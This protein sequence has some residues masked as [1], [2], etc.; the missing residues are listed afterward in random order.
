[1]QFLLSKRDNLFLVL[2]LIFLS[3]IVYSKFA[4]SL[5]MILLV[6]LSLLPDGK[7][8]IRED[9]NLLFSNK[10]LLSITLFFFI[11]FISGVNSEN[12]GEWLHQI[13]MKLPYLIMPFVLWR[14]RHMIIKFYPAYHF[15]FSSVVFFSALAVL[16]HYCYDAENINKGISQGKSMIT[17]VDHIK[18]SLFITFSVISS[19]IIIW[20][21]RLHLNKIQKTIALL[22][23]FFLVVFLHVLASRS[24]IIL[25]YILLLVLGVL[26]L[27]ES[28]KYLLILPLVSIIF[29]TP[30]IA[31]NTVPSFKSKIGYMFYDLNQYM[32]G[33]GLN[34]SDSERIYSY[35]VGYELFKENLLL[36]TGIGDLMDS[37]KIKYKS[38][39]GKEIHKY[40]H[41]Q[42]IFTIAGMGLLGLLLF[43]IAFFYPLSLVVSSKAY[44]YLFLALLILGSFT[45]ENTLERS[46][47]IAFFTFFWTCGIIYGQRHNIS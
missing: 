39:F 32:Q 20:K 29:L 1:M 27:R 44:L 19:L 28:K 15:L 30:I 13:K 14:F 35:K 46:Y 11:Y 7:I 37:C 9:V 4:L 43:L 12:V 40:P 34:Y 10:Y 25:C 36:G 2:I 33:E 31:Y 8:S 41:N 47:S 24:G 22:A 16:F 45:V 3:S 21:E 17:P 42:F 38:M 5:S 26:F 18:Y 6:L 23:C